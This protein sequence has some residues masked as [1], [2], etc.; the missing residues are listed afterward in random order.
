MSYE[1]TAMEIFELS[2]TIRKANERRDVLKERLYNEM[3]EAGR[4]EARIPMNNELFDLKVSVT[5]RKSKQ[6]DK[7]QLANDLGVPVSAINLDLLL[8][9]VEKGRL[10]ARQ[11][12]DYV[13]VLY[14]EGVSVR[15]VKA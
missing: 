11:Y 14:N 1:T 3:R 7:E 10:T 13:D 9:M 15:K 12:K 2:E 5:T 8:E 6:V 4:T